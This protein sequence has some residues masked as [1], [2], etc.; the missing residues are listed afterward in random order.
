MILQWSHGMHASRVRCP[1]CMDTLLDL[2]K[3]SCVKVLKMSQYP[4]S[5]KLCMN[6]TGF[7]PWQGQTIVWCHKIGGLCLQALWS[8]LSA[9][10]N[11]DLRWI[12]HFI[13]H[14]GINKLVK[15]RT[16]AYFCFSLLADIWFWAIQRRNTYTCKYLEAGFFSADKIWQY[17]FFFYWISLCAYKWPPLTL[18]E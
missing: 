8:R 14:A 13:T 18:G 10:F 17:F 7:K 4:V 2:A 16:H 1:R 3:P 9:N 11:I 15:E 6:Q 5:A 12:K